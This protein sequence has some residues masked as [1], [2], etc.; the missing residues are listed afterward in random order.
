MNLQG[1]SFQQRLT[2]DDMRLLHTEL[3]LLSPAIPDNERSAAQF[4]PGKLAVVPQFQRQHAAERI[5][6]TETEIRACLFP[7]ARCATGKRATAGHHSSR[8]RD[9][10]GAPGGDGRRWAHG[11]ANIRILF[12]ARRNLHPGADLTSAGATLG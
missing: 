7:A 8:Q 2:G 12:A 4:G 10:M 5:R 1:R 9:W 3:S 6:D 11:S